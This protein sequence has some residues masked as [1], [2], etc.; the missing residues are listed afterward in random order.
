[1]IAAAFLTLALAFQST[2][3][4]M[5][6]A[7]VVRDSAGGAVP[8]ASVVVRP[9]HAGPEVRATTS[10]DGRFAVIVTHDVV[11]VIVAARGF[12][13]AV[14]RIAPQDGTEPPSESG[15]I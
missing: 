14:Q 9:A 8:G 3:L 12:G 1:M 10:A 13:R 7:G 2:A 11:D 6:V 5:S 15:T 4:T